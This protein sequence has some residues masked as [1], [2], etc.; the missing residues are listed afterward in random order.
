M[1]ALRTFACTGLGITEIADHY[2]REIEVL[3]ELPFWLDR[4]LVASMCNCC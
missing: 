1:F 2:A 4:A 3:L